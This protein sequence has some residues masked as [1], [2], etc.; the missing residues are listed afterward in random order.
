MLNNLKIGGIGTAPMQS[1]NL[2]EFVCFRL[3]RG[4]I[5]SPHRPRYNGVSLYYLPSLNFLH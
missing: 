1:N 3:Q 4:K 5:G 2:R